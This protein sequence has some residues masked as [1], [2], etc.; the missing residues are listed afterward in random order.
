MIVR[1]DGVASAPL[2]VVLVLNA[3]RV[4]AIGGLNPRVVS[5]FANGHHKVTH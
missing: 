2:A 3:A 4:G 1:V 5:L